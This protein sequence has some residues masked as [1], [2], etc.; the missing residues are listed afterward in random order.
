MPISSLIFEILCD[1][2]MKAR[3]DPIDF[4]FKVDQS[5]SDQEF[6]VEL[7]YH[8]TDWHRKFKLYP[9]YAAGAVSEYM[10][11][12]Q[13]TSQVERFIEDIKPRKEWQSV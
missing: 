13:I 4:D 12:H 8:P 2:A 9:H 1:Y 11:K 10:I 3:L 7:I 6:N 5:Q